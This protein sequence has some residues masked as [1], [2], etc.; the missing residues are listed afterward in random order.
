MEEAGPMLGPLVE[1]VLEFSAVGFLDEEQWKWLV[2]RRIPRLQGLGDVVQAFRRRQPGIA[3][4]DDRVKATE[5]MINHIIYGVF[6]LSPDEID[7]IEVALRRRS[8]VLA[9]A[10]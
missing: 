7:L 8:Q 9:P 2:R 6:N 4:L 5:W 1:R 10:D 3:V